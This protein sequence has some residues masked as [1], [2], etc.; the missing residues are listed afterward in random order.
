KPNKLILIIFISSAKAELKSRLFFDEGPHP[1]TTAG[2]TNRFNK[3]Y[4]NYNDILNL[5]NLFR[6]RVEQ[7]EVFIK[8]NGL[9]PPNPD[10]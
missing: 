10:C 8:E 6:A 7:L 9:D 1:L 4:Y 2:I 5:R 3:G